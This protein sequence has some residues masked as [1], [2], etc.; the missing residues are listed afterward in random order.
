MFSTRLLAAALAVALVHAPAAH[1]GKAPAAPPATIEIVATQP[2]LAVDPIKIGGLGAMS[3]GAI[4]LENGLRKA[5]EASGDRRAVP[6][7]SELA[8]HDF[9]ARFEQALKARLAAAGLAIDVR[10]R[11]TERSDDEPLAPGEPARVLSMT[12]RHAMD[13]NFETLAI[14][15]DSWDL[16]RSL[17]G[18]GW[19]KQKLQGANDYPANRLGYSVRFRMQRLAG[20]GASEDATRWA[21]LGGAELAAMIDAGVD[22]VAAMIVHDLTPAGIA[23]RGNRKQLGFVPFDGE[24]QRGRYVTVD[25]KR[26][27]RDRRGLQAAHAIDGMTRT[28]SAQ[29]A[30]TAPVTAPE[31]AAPADAPAV[32]ATESN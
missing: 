32:P 14:S 17:R 22:E 15:V 4:F 1:A 10:T 21:A 20:S 6:L 29:A 2:D 7:R 8:G 19:L 23:D 12:P 25:G 9:T 11:R 28:Y 27:L 24:P 26:W 13:S 16:D 5:S 30:T 3:T 31:A 18:A